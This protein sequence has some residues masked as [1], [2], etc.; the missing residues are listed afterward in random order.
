MIPHQEREAA[1]QR[2]E[3]AITAALVQRTCDYA[4]VM[5]SGVI[6]TL[7]HSL[8]APISS[9]LVP[10]ELVPLCSKHSHPVTTCDWCD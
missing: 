3:Q 1:Q 9:L 10:A 8:S 4:R 2:H 6:I 7:S 5:C